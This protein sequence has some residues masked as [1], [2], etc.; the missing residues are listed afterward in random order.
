MAA[1]DLVWDTVINQGLVEL[2]VALV[3]IALKDTTHLIE[4]L[5][6]LEVSHV[7]TE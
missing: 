6:N 2:N 4:N 3:E 5:T 7:L 1:S